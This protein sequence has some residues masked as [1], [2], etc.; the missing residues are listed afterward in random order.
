MF[1]A[2]LGRSKN[3]QANPRKGIDF[4][5]YLSMKE[6][7]RKVGRWPAVPAQ[8]TLSL[9]TQPSNGETFT[10]DTKLYT[11]QT[12]LTNVDG[13]IKIGASVA[14]T[15]QNVFDAINLTGTPGTQYATAM[16]EHP[17]VTIAAFS[18]NNAVISAKTG[19]TAGNSIV[20][21]E[22]MVGAGNQFDAATL[23]TTR[24]GADEQD[25]D[26]LFWNHLGWNNTSGLQGQDYNSLFY[27]FNVGMGLN[28]DYQFPGETIAAAG[29][30]RC[31]IPDHFNRRYLNIKAIKPRLWT[32]RN[33]VASIPSPFTSVSAGKILKAI[34]V[35]SSRVA[36]LYDQIGGTAGTYLVVAS[37][38]AG[39]ALTF[40][41]PVSV[42]GGNDR[43]ESADMVL[44]N[45]DK[46]LI[47]FPNSAATS[48]AATRTAS[49]S[50][51]GITMNALVQV[52]A[53]ALNRASICKLNTD[54]ALIAW[55]NGTQISLNVVSVSGTVPSYGATSNITSSPSRPIIVQN[56]TDKAQ[57][58]YTKA[59]NCNT[60]AMTVSGTTITTGSELT[61]QVGN[62]TSSRHHTAIQV[63]TD[64]LVWMWSDFT[65]SNGDKRNGAFI[66]VTGTTITVAQNF[67]T[68]MDSGNELRDRIMTVSAG[69][70]YY[71]IYNIGIISKGKKMVVDT[72]GNTVSFLYG[73][74]NPTP[75]IGQNTQ[76]FWDTGIA[77][78]Q[79]PIGREIYVQCG[80]KLIV[81]TAYSGSDNFHRYWSSDI[82]T[83]TF[84]NFETQIGANRTFN[85][86]GLV[87]PAYLNSALN[88]NQGYL[89]IKNTSAVTVNLAVARLHVDVE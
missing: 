55:E 65:S 84:F 36:Y 66:T 83:L 38:S 5:H 10:I 9:P 49:L 47:V 81:V 48:F 52:A 53:T 56:G 51:T 34:A 79:E 46:I 64:K 30:R 32:Q 22:T 19:G 16:I 31:I 89:K 6:Y 15:Q 74:A 35:D 58:F 37:I 20:T 11:F 21:T 78:D 86:A 23:G 12:V 29:F 82:L 14:V 73:N 1:Q 61:M 24:A 39:G 7:L 40:G 71:F 25:A 62:I 41:T 27:T 63:A 13:N 50:G 57:L 17:T 43:D 75:A 4:P 87:E 80:T 2:P 88:A 42:D 85:Y 18:A 33:V 59:S 67:A 44:I 26:S 70:D 3:T 54:K 69:T 60:V 77:F 8:G 45:T 76:G 28:E 72:T 68:G